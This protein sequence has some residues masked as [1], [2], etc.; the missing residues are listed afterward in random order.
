[1]SA[2]S[3]PPISRRYA[4]AICHLN[5]ARRA[6]RL[7]IILGA[8]VSESLGMP[9]WKALINQ[10]ESALNYSSGN[11]PEAYRAEQLYQHYKKLKAGELRWKRGDNLDAAIVAGWRDIVAKCLYSNF[12]GRNGKINLSAYEG[13]IRG[14]PYLFRLGKLAQEAALV[15]THNFDDALEVAI[16][17]DPSTRAPVGRRYYS[18][19]RPEPFLR[20]GMVNIYHANGY[21][22]LRRDRRGS[23]NLILTEAGFADHLA[24]SNTEES[25]F[26]LRHLA[27]KTCIII[28]H[29]LSDGTLKNALRQHANQ[30]PA[31]IN[32]YIHWNNRGE[33]GLSDAQQNAIRDANFETYNLVTIFA[34]S[35]EIAEILKS[36]TM[37]EDELEGCLALHSITSRYVYYMVGSVSAGKSTTL[38]H[39]RDLATVEEWPAHMPAVMNRPSLGLKKVQEEK[40]DERL[41]EAIWRKNCEI[42]DIRVGLVAVDRGPLDFIAFPTKKRETPGITARKRARAVLNRLADNGM[43]DLCSGQVVVLQAEPRVLTFRQLQRGNRA[44]PEEVASGS[45]QRY[46]TRQRAILDKI[47]KRA[48]DEGSVVQTDKYPLAASMKAAARIVHLEKYVP[49]DFV[50]RLRE[51]QRGP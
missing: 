3:L 34:N 7:G 11:A 39:F 38:R 49:F 35:T 18:F 15:V 36:V 43:R 1:M 14:H 41:E 32:Y 40:I 20:R 50:L 33:A 44:N 8:G 23:E 27:D 2:G 5:Y 47:Y 29:S 22:P 31:H 46:L 37:E 17:L 48:I 6:G 24:N 28:G 26:L 21:I 30:R 13:K 12:R 4:K 10:I 51:I 25:H 42:R 9:Q 16:D 19:W 45:T